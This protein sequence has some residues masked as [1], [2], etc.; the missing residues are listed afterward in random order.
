M[1]IHDFIYGIFSKLYLYCRPN[2]PDPNATLVAVMSLKVS[3]YRPAL[4]FLT[5]PFCCRC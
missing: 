1:L 2:F 4:I 5:L 3:K